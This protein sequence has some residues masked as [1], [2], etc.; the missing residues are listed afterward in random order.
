MLR[1]CSA[2]A[3]QGQRRGGMAQLVL[4]RRRELCKVTGVAVWLSKC[5]ARALQGQQGVAIRLGEGSA[6]AKVTVVVVS[7]Y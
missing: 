3:L 6:R 1:E 5:L 7:N 2:R 4:G